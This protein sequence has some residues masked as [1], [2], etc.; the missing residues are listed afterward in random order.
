MKTKFHQRYPRY[1]PFYYIVFLI[2]RKIIRQR[3]LRRLEARTAKS[4]LAGECEDGPGHWA[5]E[6][7]PKNPVGAI[8]K[9]AFWIDD[10]FKEP[11][12][13][14]CIDNIAAL[15]ASLNARRLR[16]CS[17]AGTFIPGT[18]L[19]RTSKTKM[20]ENAWAIR[21]LGVSPTDAV[22]DLGGASTLFSFYLAGMGCS[23][24]VIDNDWGNCG[25]IYNTNYVGKKMHW[26]IR[27]Y[28]HDL[29]RP[30]PF[31]D[32]SFDA[33]FSIC[34]FEHLFCGTRRQVMREIGRVLKPAGRL[35]LTF[36]YDPPRAC[37]LSDK[38]LRFAYRDKIER[39]IIQPSG[40]EVMGNQQWLDAFPEKPF[41]GAL[42]LK[43]RPAA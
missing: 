18:Y 10:D 1:L 42:F 36:D 32:A 16:Y 3:A 39:D 26:D 28:D 24:R 12:I 25:T 38:G 23:V 5:R 14:E 43:K 34:V 8:N 35:A 30:L 27:A 20:W 21:H 29:A 6:D 17:P 11:A 2:L 41:L 15:R 22:L 33:V 7:K 9:A 19:P 13:R 37:G 40:L 4:P 31:K